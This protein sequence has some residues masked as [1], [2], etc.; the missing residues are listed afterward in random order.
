MTHWTELAM[1]FIRSKT[2]PI[3]FQGEAP[4]VRELARKYRIKQQEVVD[5]L[6]GHESLCMNVGIGINGGGVHEFKSIGDFNFEWM[7]D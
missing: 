2:F 1:L 3:Y 7:E 6:E 5:E 4:T